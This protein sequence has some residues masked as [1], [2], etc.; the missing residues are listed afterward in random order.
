MR[1]YRVFPRLPNA[2]PSDPGGALFRASGGSSRIDNPHLYRVLYVSREPECAISEIFGAVALWREEM[3][4]HRDGSRYALAAIE[5]PDD[6][7][8]WNMDDVKHLALLRLKP[9][10]VIRR[11]L[12]K[13]QSWAASVWQLNKYRGIS[14]WSY[15]NSDWTAYGLWDVDDAA[16]TEVLPLKLTMP[17]VRTAAAAIVRPVSAK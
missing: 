7:P 12:S 1:V 15:Y 10:D 11:N 6:R 8:I 16:V 17:A 13:T 3:L 4:V 9:T 5:L 2:A 14:W